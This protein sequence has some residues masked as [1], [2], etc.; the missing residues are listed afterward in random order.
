MNKINIGLF[1]DTFYP[2]IDGVIMVVDNYAKR[3]S[4]YANVYV[5]APSSPKEQG[6]STALYIAKDVL[7]DTGACRVHGGG[8]AGTIQVF[9]PKSEIE[10]Y[11]T[12]MKKVFGENSCYI[13]SVRSH[14]GYEI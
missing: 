1:I 13:L 8:F 6:L 10:N 4:K 7:G 5:F 9:L 12:A 3:L 2:M 11:T 14:G